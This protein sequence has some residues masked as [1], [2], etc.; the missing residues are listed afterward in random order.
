MA[1]HNTIELLSDSGER[2]TLYTGPRMVH[3]PRPL[4]PRPRE[5]VLP[6]LV[7]LSA[8]SATLFV[9]D[10]YEGRKMRGVK[11][12]SIEKLLVL[13]DL[14]KPANYHGGGTTPIAHGGSW[15]L[16]RI[17]GT[18]PV[19]KDGSA[20]FEAPP[21][22]SLYFALLDGQD[23]SVKQMRSFVTLQPGEQR[24]CVGCHERRTQSPPSLL[25]RRARRPAPSRIEPIAGVPEIIDFPRDVQP[26]LDRHCVSCHDA[27]KREGGIVLTGHRGPTY[28]LAYYNLI[29]HRQITDGAG[30]RWEGIENVDGR[31]IGNDEPYTM[32]SSASPLMDKIDGSHHE[33]ELSREEQTLVRLWIDT[34]AQYAGTYA[35]YGTGQIGGWWRNNEPIREMADDWPTT[36]PATES[37]ERRCAACHG[38]MLPRSVTDS[39][40]VDGFG[41]L[42]G[43]QRPT[44]RFSR[45]TVFDLTQ[46]EESLLLMT[47]LARESGGYAVGT[48]SAPEMIT[49][50][51]SKAPRPVQHPVVFC[52]VDDPDYQVI[53][54]HLRAAQTRLHEI[55]RFDME[56]FEPRPE[57]VREMV[58]FGVLPAGRDPARRPIDVY[59]TDRRYWR[60]LWHEP[61]VGQ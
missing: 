5:P 53:L 7:D 27:E 35:A 24:G 19:A 61:G 57:Y 22:R 50:D 45:H 39:V 9:A 15:T 2:V 8:N 3:E 13:E 1:R 21:L 48:S 58:R 42:E 14:P 10:V 46:P 6:S 34:A 31:P 23:R 41:D 51:R 11:R 12:G 40:P 60:S 4:T 32:Y 20:C 38:A 17:L 56:G 44:S 26:I 54:A 16:K 37:I 52:S 49:E 29:L 18:V 59:E 25:G 30:Y 43:W 47:P 55:K 33:V 28:S 36:R